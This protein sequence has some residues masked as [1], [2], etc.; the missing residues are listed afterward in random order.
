V[1]V[2][3]RSERHILL[4]VLVGAACGSSST[5][6]ASRFCQSQLVT[7][8]QGGTLTVTSPEC[9]ALAGTKVI[10]PPAALAR[11]TVITVGM[12][13]GTIV[14][15]GAAAIGPIV[16]LG[17]SGT[18]FNF[19]VV[20]TLPYMA[21]SVFDSHHVFVQRLEATGAAA[22]IESADLSFPPSLGTLSFLVRSFT[23]F[24][25]ALDV[26]SCSDCPKGSA[27]APGTDHCV[28][29]PGLYECTDGGL[30]LDLRLDSHNCGSCGNV[31]P[32]MYNC[33]IRH[34]GPVDDAGAQCASIDCG[35]GLTP[36]AVATG[37]SCVDL[38]NDPQNCGSCANA[39]PLGYTCAGSHCVNSCDGGLA[40]CSY[41]T[42]FIC[43]DVQSDSRNCGACALTCDS[44][45]AGCS[46]GICACTDPALTACIAEGTNWL[47]SCV[48]LATDRANCGACG[49]HCGT[50]L[51]CIAN[52][53]GSND[54]GAHCGC[55]HGLTHCVGCCGLGAG[56]FDLQ[57]DSHNCGHCGHT[58]LF[59][60]CSRGICCPSEQVGCLD[61]DAGRQFCASLATDPLNCGACGA[62]CPGSTQCIDGGCT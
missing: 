34:A 22:R 59:Q 49:V 38:S 32:P 55:D 9:A 13:S 19:N 41:S 39:C 29:N 42:G 21:S 44:S 11:D 45:T 37:F 57:S 33:D 28:C 48:N 31:C 52:A 16:D 1:D 17:P 56:C 30:C 24:E 6:V 10:I 20:V 27:C 25:V 60:A 14:P 12:G 3:K 8:A 43:V 46:K 18:Q 5:Q 36:C 47:F 15:A 7:A 53:G 40:P 2:L 54:A 50:G 51:I 61:A 35:L 23:Q 58:C 26:S 4:L 62:Q